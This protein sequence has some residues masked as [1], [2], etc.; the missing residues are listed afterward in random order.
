M[1]PSMKFYTNKETQIEKYLI[2]STMIMVGLSY[3]F[4]FIYYPHILFEVFSKEF[5]YTA[6]ILQ[7][8]LFAI[9]C[10]LKN[11]E[12]AKFICVFPSICMMNILIFTFGGL[13]S[14]AVLW[15]TGTP[16]FM[17]VFYKR[18]GMLT[19]VFTMIFIFVIFF[20]MQENINYITSALTSEEYDS[21]LKSNIIQFSA[22]TTVYFSFYIWL[23]S[24]HRKRL[25]FT[26]KQLDTLLHVVLHDL[27]NPITILKLKIYN[28]SRKLGLDKKSEHQIKNSFQKIEEIITSVR[29]FQL[30][31]EN[32]NFQKTEIS[33]DFIYDYSKKI[34]ESHNTKNLKLHFD[35]DTKKSFLCEKRVLTDHILG[36]VI[37]NAIKF[38]HEGQDILIKVYNDTQRFYID[39]IDKGVGI[40]KELIKDIFQFDKKTSRIGTGGELGT[41]Y[42]LPIVKYFTDYSNG[43][44]NIS[45]EHM[46]GTKVSLAFN[47]AKKRS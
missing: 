44:V 24:N 14:P 4:Y 45:S 8:S 6:A 12:M 16:I 7:F 11:H 46:I 25:I 5:F 9:A 47:L 39:V 43:N 19:G 13:R 29:S 27:S 3:L 15:T 18:T 20:L 21:L 1:C 34:F 36:N 41:G 42:G 10:L 31:S 35:I 23:E 26:N 2:I 32:L 17:G 37:T 38:S 30:D 22:L 40:P 33:P 28:L